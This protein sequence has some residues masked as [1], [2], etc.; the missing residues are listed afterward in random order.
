VTLHEWRTQADAD[1]D[2]LALI[3]AALH[4]D[5]VA[6]AALLGSLDRGQLVATC[7]SLALWASVYCEVLHGHDG[8]LDAVT[9]HVRHVRG[10]AA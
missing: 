9:A 5:R 3:V 10:D 8:A 7:W 2:P 1:L 6:G 4:D